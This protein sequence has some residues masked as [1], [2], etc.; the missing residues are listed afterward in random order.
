MKNIRDR[1]RAV[2]K[3]D[4]KGSGDQV[5]D[6][7][8]RIQQVTD[9]ELEKMYKL[10][11]T[12]MES[13][14]TGM[15]VI[16]AK[17]LKDGVEVVIKTRIKKESFKS[18]SEEREW[19]STTEYQLNMPSVATLCQF[20]EVLETRSTYYVI[21]EKV[22][23]QDLFEQMAREKL[24]AVESRDVM[25][26]ILDALRVMHADGRIHRDLKIENVMI[27]DAGQVPVSPG[28]KKSKDYEPCSPKSAKLIDFDTVQDW[29]PSSPKAKDVLGTD[30]YIAP[31]AYGGDYSPASDVYSAGVILYKMMTAK[32]PSRAELFD[33][34]P[35][36]NYVGSAAMKRIQARLE[37]EVIN[38]NLH[39][40]D[41]IPEAQ[42]LLKR[43]L[44]YDPAARL[45]A[46]EAMNHDFFRLPPEQLQYSPPGR[47]PPP[48]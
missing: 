21:M 1:A 28:G 12:V 40:L 37:K 15:D 45:T 13:T 19:R 4:V 3:I 31:E 24:T 26:N 42:D 5:A 16:F 35:G 47:K 20:Y 33:D 18:S 46:E 14:N 38:F 10:G 32:F 44:A 17:R 30:G 29:E 43:M 36:E 39:P 22:D 7:K 27:S 8:R 2:L 25:W 48:S 11:G 6:P 41:K 23:G 9:A 34:Q